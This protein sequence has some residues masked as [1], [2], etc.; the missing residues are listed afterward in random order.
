MKRKFEY[1]LVRIRASKGTIGNSKQ[2]PTGEDAYEQVIHK[3]AGEGWRLCDTWS[4]PGVA[5]AWIDLIFE[6]E[7]T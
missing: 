5:T 4:P 1:K 3:H 2:K 7:I 6:R